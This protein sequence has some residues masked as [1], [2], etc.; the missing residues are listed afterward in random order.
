[1]RMKQMNLK[2]ATFLLRWS[3]LRH[4]EN[5]GGEQFRWN[6][7]NPIQA[8]GRRPASSLRGA[9]TP[10]ANACHLHRKDDRRKAPHKLRAR[11]SPLPVR[12]LSVLLS[13][14]SVI[15]SPSF[16][17]STKSMQAHA[18]VALAAQ[19]LKLQSAYCAWRW[20]SR[21]YAIKESTHCQQLHQCMPMQAT[22]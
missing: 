17:I 19:M 15:S 3:V 4:A 5:M 9:T 20:H 7:W 22:A 14:L 21:P 11:L 12:L 6:S 13:S 2:P 1:M 16:L 10:N 8:M 18:A